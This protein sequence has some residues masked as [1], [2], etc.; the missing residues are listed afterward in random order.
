MENILSFGLA[1]AAALFTVTNPLSMMPALLSMTQG[2][3]E[4][5][6]TRIV[7]RATIFAFIT[8]LV[9]VLSGQFIFWFFGI[10]TDA[11][12]IVGGIIL[13]K[14]GY[15][16]LN[17]KM[18]TDSDKRENSSKASFDDVAIMPLGIPMLC[19]P[20]VIA[21]AIVKMEDAQTYAMKGV[22]LLSIIV[23]YII[24]FYVLKASSKLTKL[25]GTTGNNV[26]VKLMGLILM[27]I[28]IECMVGGAKPI[29]A[30]IIKE[31]MLRYSNMNL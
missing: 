31:G 3:T 30:E 8:L 1:C 7:R 15:D 6:R 16:M 21:T 28:A 17:A 4:E 12:R 24:A 29:L 13:M 5:E 9:F 10:S 14:V 20:A 26:M 27:V 19:G 11:F 2:A 25:L 18:T 23:I 22:L